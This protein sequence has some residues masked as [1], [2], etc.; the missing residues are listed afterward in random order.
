MFMFFAPLQNWRAVKITERR[1]KVD[2]A[3]CMRDLADI[4]F[5]QAK[6]IVMVQ[7][8]LNTHLPACLY[9]GFS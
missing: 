8:Q 7:D 1:T 4:H 6:K 2:W 5:S 3:D 9:E